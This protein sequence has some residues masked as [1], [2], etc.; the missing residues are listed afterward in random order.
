[1]KKQAVV[2]GIMIMMLLSTQAFA[3]K[4]ESARSS[5]SYSSGGGMS[6]FGLGIRGGHLTGI[7][8]KLWEGSTAFDIAIGWYADGNNN[9]NNNNSSLTLQADYL[10]HNFASIS[11]G[12]LALHYGPG[13]SVT[14]GSNYTG[15]SFRIPV[16]IDF[17][18]PGNRVDI[19]A[20]VAPSLAL[21]PGT[22]FY[23]APSIGA[24]FYF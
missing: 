12:K 24:R 8:L 18:F 4:K 10:M 20:E 3:A 16:G 17:I 1:M 13:L 11:P 15:M 21:L 5:S 14:A 19:F 22:S 23:I 7:D 2:I 6:G 9:G